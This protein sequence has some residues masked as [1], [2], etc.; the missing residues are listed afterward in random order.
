MEFPGVLKKI[1]YGN[2]EANKKKVEFPGMI[3]K[4]SYEISFGLAS[5]CVEFPRVKLQI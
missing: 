1:E 2:S 3:K 5:F 4:K